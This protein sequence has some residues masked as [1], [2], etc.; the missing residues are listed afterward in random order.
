MQP[1]AVRLSPTQATEYLN[2]LE[3]LAKELEAATEAIIAGALPSLEES[4]ARQQAE[5]SR[6]IAWTELMAARR[7]HHIVPA[8]A[9]DAELMER[10]LTASG[11]LLKLNR[12]YSALLK[13]S[14]DTLRL[15][16]GL[17]RSYRGHMQASALH[18][19]SCEL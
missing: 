4:V 11:I 5:C 17:S 15:L 16:S 13:H 10:I 9:A 8:E 18:T 3:G 19:F 12:R 1:E 7:A 14:G 2:S 6:L